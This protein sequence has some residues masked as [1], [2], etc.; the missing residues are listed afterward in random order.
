MNYQGFRKKCRLKVFFLN[1]RIIIFNKLL[2]SYDT[3][4][5]G[6]HSQSIRRGHKN[7]DT[8]YV[9]GVPLTYDRPQPAVSPF[10]ARERLHCHIGL[11]S[12]CPTDVCP[13]IQLATI[14]DVAYGCTLPRVLSVKPAINGCCAGLNC[15]IRSRGPR[16]IHSLRSSATAELVTT[17]S[18]C[19]KYIV[20]T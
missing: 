10:A 3:A 18:A 4:T 15:T 1:I 14:V 17:S 7:I 9:Y 11:T 13:L 16:A 12:V 19:S 5:A 2:Y 8:Q 20:V 6:W